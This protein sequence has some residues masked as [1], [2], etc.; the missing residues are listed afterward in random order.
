MSRD[1]RN[2]RGQTAYDYL[3]GI[4]LL[5]VTIITVISV[6]PQVFGPFVDPVSTDQNKMSDRVAAQIIEDNSTMTGERTL[7]LDGLNETVDERY[8]EALKNRS[9]VPELRRVNIT[10]R[11]GPGAEPIV[12]AG[13]Q[14]QPG[15]PTATVVRNIRAVSVPEGAND[16]C[17]TGCQLIVRVW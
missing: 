17:E 4:V 6:F 2:E 5:L 15:E 14:R 7:D 10:V 16:D 9:G 11:S 3:L 13:D 1:D 12:T 8:V